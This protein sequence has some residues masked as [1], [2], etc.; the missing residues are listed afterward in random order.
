MHS[1]IMPVLLCRVRPAASNCALNGAMTN[2]SGPHHAGLK[3]YS[4]KLWC[5]RWQWLTQPS[6]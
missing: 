6:Y 4:F 2:L 1:S 5:S 3:P